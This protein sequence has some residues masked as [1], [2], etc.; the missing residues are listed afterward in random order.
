MYGSILRLSLFMLQIA[1]GNR[2]NGG[3]SEW[4]K[5]GMVKGMRARWNES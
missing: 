4:R 2:G 5:G 3:M 1:Q